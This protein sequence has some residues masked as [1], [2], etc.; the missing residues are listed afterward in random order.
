MNNRKKILLGVLT[1]FV[2][3]II[4]VRIILLSHQIDM[5]IQSIAIANYMNDSLYIKSITP[6]PCEEVL[7]YFPNL[8]VHSVHSLWQTLANP[9]ENSDS[10]ESYVAGS[11]GTFYQYLN[12]SFSEDV[13]LKAVS[14]E[15]RCFK[16]LGGFVEA[17]NDLTPKK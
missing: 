10:W 15:P 5:V 4:V 2:L 16:I 7:Q 11:K 1:I 13:L 17:V 9:L 6:V 8:E 14:K 12:T 3:I